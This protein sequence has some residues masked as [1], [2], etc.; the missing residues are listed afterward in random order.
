VDTVVLSTQHDPM[1]NGK[2][3]QA[4]LKKQVIQHIIKPVLG[5]WFDAKKITVPREP[6]GPS[7]SAGR[8]ATPA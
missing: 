8:T 1:W 3:K 5:K 6:H 2:A 7:R 4:Q